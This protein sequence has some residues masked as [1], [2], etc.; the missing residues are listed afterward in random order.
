MTPACSRLTEC[1]PC[2]SW[3]ADLSASVLPAVVRA[4]EV[5]SE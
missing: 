2:V 4:G 5:E 3:G 1:S